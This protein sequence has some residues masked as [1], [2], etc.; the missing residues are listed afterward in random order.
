VSGAQIAAHYFYHDCH[1]ARA[2]GGAEVPR[3]PPRDGIVPELTAA[4]EALAAVPCEI[5]HGR[6]DVSA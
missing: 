4:R 1:L 3:A 6:H 2:G 5:I